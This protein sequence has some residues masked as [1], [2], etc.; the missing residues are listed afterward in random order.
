MN[1]KAG[2]RSKP[3]KIIDDKYPPHEAIYDAMM[4]AQDVLERVQI[5]FVVLGTTAYQMVHGEQLKVHK[6]VLGVLQQHAVDECTSLIPTVEP[7]VQKLTDGW[8]I[9]RHGV[10][11][12]I[13]LIPKQ[14]PTIM[15]PDILF[16]MYDAWKVPNPFEDYWNGGDHYD[17]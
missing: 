17:V 6:V 9:V 14:Y 3:Q 16:Y 1:K 10:P 11:V 5:P 8:Q 4:H 12:Y 13:K 7:S 15:N 2:M